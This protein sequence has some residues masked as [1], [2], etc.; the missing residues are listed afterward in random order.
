[1]RTPTPP[2]VKKLS[3]IASSLSIPHSIDEVMQY[4]PYFKA[5]HTAVDQESDRD[6][7]QRHSIYI[8]NHM[9]HKGLGRVFFLSFLASLTQDS[10]YLK[11]L[12][13]CLCNE[14]YTLEQRYFFYWQV[15]TRHA[16][17]AGSP[18]PDPTAIYFE[19]LD[20]YRNL[21]NI[22]FSWIDPKDRKTDT[23]V[24]FTNQ[25]LGIRHAPTADCLDY[26]YILQN[27]LK[28]RIALINT[29]IMPWTMSLPYYDPVLFNYEESYS[30]GAR[31]EFRGEAF[32]F[33][34]CHFP[35]PNL[36]EIDSLVR[37]VLE[38]RPAFILNLGH[39]NI[40]ADICAEFLTV[41]TMPFG[42][43]L[44]TS[45][46]NIFI[47]PRELRSD[48]CE[49]M[50]RLNIARERVVEIQ[51]TFRLPDRSAVLTREQLG[52]PNDAYVIAVVGNR[53]DEE[54]NDDFCAELSEFLL[55][56]PRAFLALMGI[57]QGYGRLVRKMP[58][59]GRQ[60]VFLG[61]QKDI[62]A[63]YDCCDAYLNP[64]RGGGGSSA[65]F[66]LAVGLPV[67]T[68]SGGDVANIVGNQFIFRSLSE[69]KNFVE[70][71][72]VDHEHR[73]QWAKKAK[74]RFAEISDREGMLSH[75]IQQIERRG[76]LR[77]RAHLQTI[78]TPES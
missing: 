44:S 66:A 72:L 15:I 12:Y 41:A 20:S 5:A 57:F 71:S 29:A 59:I 6:E 8:R 19:I 30:S 50:K 28:K 47:L 58:V 34:Q 22:N 74:S 68:R 10:R 54:M 78:H 56:T 33:Y 13:E 39:S 1:M 75:I 42:T 60:S 40:A 45:G 4:L 73:Q 69:V 77:E 52:L 76:N 3:E 70:K 64:P 32:D 11:D 61:H 51:Y 2:E 31:F 55:S 37:K 9:P 46:G 38:I 62:L 23:I 49:F 18:A 65:A 48:D 14:D 36:K 24:I 7:K 35:M 26:C 63:V 21:L 17:A 16:K 25:M 53:L 67:F 43:N 27:R